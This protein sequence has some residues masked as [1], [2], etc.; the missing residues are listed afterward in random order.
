VADSDSLDDPDMQAVLQSAPS[1]QS[2]ATSVGDPDMDAVLANPRTSAESVYDPNRPTIGGRLEQQLHEM[3][4]GTYHS[5]LGG[6]EGI[7]TGLKTLDLNKAAAA[8]TAEQAQA[9]LAPQDAP[10]KYDASFSLPAST[11]LGDIASRRGAPPWLSTTLAAAPTALAS[12]LVPRSAS[13][14]RAPV[15]APM[16]AA[17]PP[18]ALSASVPENFDS[19][20]IEGGVPD[21]A[22]NSRQQVLRRV[23][24][25]MA[26]QSAIAGDA[27][28]AATDWQLSKF[29]EPAGAE[30]KAQFDAEK[31][32][33]AR[34][35][36][37][38]VDDTGGTLGTDE[39]TLNARGRTIAA[40]FDQL[41]Q[42]FDKQK[43]QAY[44]T[45]TE[46]AEGQPI[47][48]MES[49][50]ALLKDPD[51]TETLLAKD[52]GGLLNSIQ[53]QFQRFKDLNPGGISKQGDTMVADQGM[54]PENAENF[55]KWMNQV[56]TPDNS[57]TLG[58]VKGAVDEDVFRGAGEDVYGP[59][60][61]TAQ[62]EYQTLDN[63]KGV[64]RLMDFDPQNP[65]NRTTPYAK[66]PDT[67]TRLDPDQF[68][69]VLKTLDTMPEDIQP[70]AQAA[71]AEIK[72]HLANKIFDAGSSTQGQ[73]N[74][75]GVS[76]VIK[77][78]S[79]KLQSAFADQPE[80][81]NKISDLDSAGKI[82]KVDQSYPGAA[83]QAANVLRRGAMSG[84]IGK[85]ATSGGAL[86]GSAAGSVLGPAG[87]A[88]G[89]GAG[90]AL[91][92]STGSRLTR[93]MTEKAAVKRWQSGLV[94]L[95]DVARG[96]QP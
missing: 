59:A 50:E 43:Q 14:E 62:M 39:D 52:Q 86:V 32:A 1:A 60:R 6:Y 49:T 55:R 65:L 23:G 41:R 17:N 29:D 81:L 91:G 84:V 27:K 48:P 72:A 36:S 53:R 80:V 19:P 79:A 42:W 85:L 22:Q 93:G 90:A 35:A 78:N 73:W 12:V 7:Y 38:I 31:S 74:T 54:T 66:I 83:A 82:L 63:P 21:S 87:A 9:Y 25:N 24:L 75:A 89:S 18:S 16:P 40:P 94:P 37:G 46:R 26:R 64:S 5:I 88:V 2:S 96:P 70:A 92:E 76:K 8:V 28:A 45:A 34:H 33:L 10:T 51:F 44:A 20:P 4:S 30:A 47:G 11:E 15:E 61:Q 69:N 57:A 13:A 68:D 56:W 71:K 3:A 77:A 95:S 58:K 67:L